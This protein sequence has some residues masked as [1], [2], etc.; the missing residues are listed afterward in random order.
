MGKLLTTVVYVTNS[1]WFWF[2]LEITATIIAT[3]SCIQNLYMAGTNKPTSS[4]HHVII[5]IAKM[6]GGRS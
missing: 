2:E 6:Y 1:I 3:P 4:R 5:H